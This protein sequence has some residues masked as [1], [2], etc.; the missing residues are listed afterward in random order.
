[1]VVAG[2][3]VATSLSVSGASI[4]AVMDETNTSLSRRHLRRRLDEGERK[5]AESLRQDFNGE[6]SA[7]HHHRSATSSCLPNQ[8][9]LILT[10]YTDANSI[11]DNSWRISHA[12]INGG[13]E[14]TTSSSSSGVGGLE[15]H[16][17]SVGSGN[18]GYGAVVIDSICA[19]YANVT[20]SSS[21][22]HSA[23]SIEDERQEMRHLMRGSSNAGSVLAHAAQARRGA[24][25]A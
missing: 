20:S 7:S 19:D 2:L 9:N 6:A 8:H 12:D 23:A 4:N 14:S 24:G 11:S 21:S 15:I 18:L 5:N 17:Q 10:M 16:S 1:M 22:S 25:E 3:F 13:D